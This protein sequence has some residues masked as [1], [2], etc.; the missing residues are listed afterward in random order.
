MGTKE[1]GWPYARISRARCL[2]LALSVCGLAVIVST[3]TA[4]AVDQR[5]VRD[6]MV[7]L[8]KQALL[9]YEAKDYQT[10][11]DLLN[12]ALKEAKQAGL[13]DDKMT[14][15]TYL[16]LGAVYWVGFQDQ[17][18][19]IQNFI[20]SK[21]IRPDIQLTPS[22]E[23]PDLKSVFDLAVVEPE[24]TPTPEP[25]NP[26]RPSTP[27]P[28]PGPALAGSNEPDLPSSM[29]SSL[30]CATPEES[31]P[32]KELSIRCALKPGI[33][34]DSVQLHYRAL[35]AESY[36]SLPMHRTAKGWYLATLPGHVMTGNSIQVYY[37]ARDA[38]DSQLA[39]NGQEDSPS[40]IEIRKRSYGGGRASRYDREGDPLAGIKRQQEMEKY[41]AG[42]HRRRQG[43]VWFNVL[44]GGTGWGYA[45]AGNLEW[46]KDQNG[47]PI[48][49]SAVTTTT[50][51]FHWVPEL[52][53]ML[54]DNFA[55][56]AQVRLEYVRQDQ[57]TSAS[58]RSGAPTQW[59][60]AAFLRALWFFDVSSDG[61]F[62]FLTG[63]SIGGGY[64]RFPVKPQILGYMTDP[65]TDQRVPDPNLTIAKTDTRPMG[66]GLLGPSAGFIYH[67]S[68]HFAL[69]LEARALVGFPNFGFAIE[70]NGS[71][72][73]A[74]GGKAGPA[75]EEE[76]EEEGEESG[77]ADDVPPLY[78][79]EED[80]EE[81]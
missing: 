79:D 55:I 29:P 56:S 65:Q 48:K 43:A 80:E 51:M 52:G 31:P 39:N 78:S 33:R 10:A 22:I 21:K 28:E 34:A 69:A 6:H 77:V 25:A 30:M 74:L 71:F 23:T 50:G 18:A 47:K 16:H 73:I 5:K 12:K 35:G 62:Q 27:T 19:A 44:A 4:Y 37:D 60:P 76:E 9:S 24:P 68:R 63:A 32:G 41:E 57:I 26:S 13:E 58:N 75:V 67:M 17:P 40:V 2:A 81:E 46:A 38:N 14:A 70:G 66:T 15:R 61:N 1:L 53:Y 11:R 45:P 42:L 72:L 7:D 3:G 59:A 64:V 36:Q 20:L 8:N 54:T 49:V